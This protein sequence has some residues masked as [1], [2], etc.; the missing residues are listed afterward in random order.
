MLYEIDVA[1]DVARAADDADGLV[2]LA[3]E[4]ETVISQLQALLPE[5]AELGVQ[6]NEDRDFD[7]AAFVDSPILIQG[8]GSEHG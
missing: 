5:D 2:K 6:H 3:N 1:M 4:R 8:D 7:K